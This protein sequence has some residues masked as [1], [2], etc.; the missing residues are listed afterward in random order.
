MSP[1]STRDET[2][3]V[4]YRA[5]WTRCIWCEADTCSGIFVRVRV[6]LPVSAEVAEETP[7]LPQDQP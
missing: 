6:E 7:L 5:K 1:L 3:G 2:T 4:V